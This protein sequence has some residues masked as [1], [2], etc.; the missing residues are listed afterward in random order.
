MTVRIK[1]GRAKGAVCAPPSKSYAHRYLLGASLSK[2]GGTVSGVSE[3]EDMKATL[4]CAQSL[5]ARFLCTGDTVRFLEATGE[6]RDSFP[7]RESGSTLRFFIPIALAK[8][9]KATFTGSPRLFSRGISVYEALFAEKGISVTKTA[10][11]VTLSGKLSAGDYRVRGDV[12]SQFITGLLY[13]LPLLEEDST[14]SVLPPVESRSYIDLTLD[15]LRDF[16]IVI[17]E[18]ATNEFFIR[19]NQSF[20]FSKAT[21]EGDWSNAAFLLALNLLGGELTVSGLNGESRQGDRVC[22][23][24]FEALLGENPTIDL[25]DCPDLAPVLFAL[26]AK[27]GGA[28][29]IGTARLKIKESDRA[30]AM[31]RELAKL[32]AKSKIE[33][34]AVT[35]FPSVLHAPTE[36]L[37]GHNDHRV[38]MAL[39]V[40]LT[41]FGGEIT[42]AE[43]VSKS[44]PE[45][46]TVLRDCG[47]EVSSDAD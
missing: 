13:A 15:T 22:L 20:A 24:L 18:R 8:M 29:F 1:K 6:L 4:D 36:A 12:S 23:S 17:E 25:S 27:T 10:S 5:G 38:V 41:A 28:R 3:S 40:L 32:G 33:E 11:S 21:V 30:E 26:A 16:G 19:G 35:I 7:C 43:A 42:G 44:F 39:A 31:C 2:A 9:Q 34:N 45:F 37:C 47:I 14:L 46:F